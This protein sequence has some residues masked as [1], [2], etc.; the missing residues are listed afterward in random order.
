MFEQNV[1]AGFIALDKPIEDYVQE[2]QNKNTREKTRR[3]VSLL[4]EFLKQKGEK[5]KLEE[6]KPDEINKYL[7][8][9]ILS[10]KRKDGEDYESSSLRGLFS[11]VNRFLKED[12]S[13]CRKHYR[14]QKV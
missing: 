14:P 1:R 4:S 7:Y 3:D 12:K 13:V 11:S 10:I 6:I 5:R 8:E 2:R 9:F